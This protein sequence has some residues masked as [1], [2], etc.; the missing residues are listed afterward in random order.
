MR[1]R[2]NLQTK[3][4]PFSRFTGLTA[5]FFCFLGM[6]LR[7][8]GVRSTRSTKRVVVVVRRCLHRDLAARNVLVA[9]GYVVKVADFGMA[10]DLQ[11]R[12]GT[13]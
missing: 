10:R 8:G 1:F 13:K 5:T 7:G 2:P 9:D 4:T 12:A 6:A 11:V 3:L